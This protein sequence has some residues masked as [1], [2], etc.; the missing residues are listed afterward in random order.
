M[1][2]LEVS[3]NNFWIIN[4]HSEEWE[5]KRKR[6]ARRVEGKVS[7]SFHP[8]QTLNLRALCTF[9]FPTDRT[10]GIYQA[11][12]YWK[13]CLV[14]FRG[15]CVWLSQSC[16]FTLATWRVQ[17]KT[18][19]IH[20]SSPQPSFSLPRSLLPVLLLQ[21]ITT[22]RSSVNL[23]LVPQKHTLLLCSQDGSDEHFY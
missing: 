3:L 7:S 22:D 5:G 16:F 17:W 11:E 1:T 20:S 6:E 13:L 12:M 19:T 21:T 4:S 18:R 23:Q 9:I 14:V 8:P 2:E 15:R 10:S